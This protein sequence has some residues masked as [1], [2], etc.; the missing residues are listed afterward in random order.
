MSDPLLSW[1]VLPA[2]SLG[3]G[4]VESSSGFY[5]V[6]ESF[7]NSLKDGN[8]CFLFCFVVVVVAAV[9]VVAVVFEKHGCESVR[10]NVKRIE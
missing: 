10:R 7:V 4:L 3:L 8:V 6:F 2:G 5:D 9:V 1:T